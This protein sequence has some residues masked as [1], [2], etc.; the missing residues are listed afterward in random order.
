MFIVESL[1]DGKRIPVHARDKAVSLG[2]IAIFTETE[3]LPLGEVLEKVKVK[4]DGKTASIDPKSD[5]NVLNKYMEE[6][7]PDYDKERVY[8]SDI[9]KL[10][11][12][13]NILIN[14]GITEFLSK[15]TEEEAD[16]NNKETELKEKVKKETKPT[17]KKAETKIQA[18]QP[19]TVQK[20]V[21]NRK[22]GS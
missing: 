20:S 12:W 6:V 18:K 13:Y 11:S 19:K 17:V 16:A 9:K 14:K 21:T 10:I 5:T 15:E 8:P 2:D 1:I 3:E 7:L 4:E 22:I